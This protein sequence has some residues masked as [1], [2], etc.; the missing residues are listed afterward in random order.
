MEALLSGRVAILGIGREGQVAW[1]YLRERFPGVRLAL[2]AE[3]QPDPGFAQQLTENDSLLIGPLSKARLEG[4]D[5][6][7][8]SPGISPYRKS[9]RR[10]LDSGTRIVTPSTLWFAEHPCENT[11]CITGTKGKSTTSALLAHMLRACGFRVCLAGNIGV[12]LLA[13]QERKVDWWVIELSSY[14]LADLQAN[15]DI[16]MILNLSSEHLDWHGNEER[17]RDDKLKLVSLAAGGPVIAN[18]ADPVLSAA[19]AG[20]DNT[21]WFNAESGIRVVAQGLADAETPMPV[22]LPEGLPGT[23]NLSNVA[24]ALTALRLVGADLATGL[25]SLPSFA[26]L[27]HRLQSIG[28]RDGVLFVNDSISSTPLAT[29]AALEAYAG[30]EITLIVGGLDRGLDWTSYMEPIRQLMPVAVIGIPA[31]GFRIVRQM[32]DI[33]IVPRNGL[34]MFETLSEA[35]ELAKKLTPAGG[36]VLLSP[37]APSFPQFRDYRERGQQFA[38][39]CGFSFREQDLFPL[40][41]NK[42]AGQG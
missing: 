13:C 10:A 4:F 30:K 8:R 25:D 22:Q 19:L 27:P 37:G 35:V 36:V 38:K 17:Y 39:L 12:P 6:L 31:N 16:S 40:E 20:R 5:L 11:I 1:R 7:V 18:A 33:D 26:S 28:K 15:P 34:H 32:E 41:I 9:V 29:V 42:A 23:H 24:A 2:L 21:E 14:Q 3:S